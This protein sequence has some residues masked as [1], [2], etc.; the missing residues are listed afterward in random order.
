MVVEGEGMSSS[1]SGREVLKRMVMWSGCWVGGGGNGDLDLARV[2]AD[3]GWSNGAVGRSLL[4]EDDEEPTLVSRLGRDFLLLLL[5][6]MM[7]VGGGGM[8]FSKL[9]IGSWE[10]DDAGVNKRHGW[11]R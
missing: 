10:D 3:D 7:A 9:G 5:L 6:L 1:R 8:V 2:G 11:G 4:E